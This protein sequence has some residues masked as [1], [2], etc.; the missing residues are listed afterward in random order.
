M[1]ETIKSTK[2]PKKV[3]HYEIKSELGRGGMATVYL[4]Y[5]ERFER[6]VAV[7]VL[8]AEF[9]HDP[10]FSVRFHREAKIIAT[11][12]HPAIVPVYDVGEADGLP[13]FVMRY[14][15]GGSL[16]DTLAKGELNLKE[17]ARII[18]AIAPALDEA[19]RRGIIH[20]DLKPANILFD[21]SN[22]PYLSDFGIA[23]MSDSQT[24]VTGSAIIGTPA[25][26]SPEQARGLKVD[27]RSDVYA[28]GA[29]IYR[30][31]TGTRPFEGD[32]PMS[33]AVKH[34][35]DPTPDILQDNADLPAGASTFI[36]HAMAKEPDERFQT[37]AELAEALNALAHDG[38]MIEPK[39]L[40]GRTR[41]SRRGAKGAS[42]KKKRSWILPVVIAGIVVV[43]AVLG[44]MGF[45]SN[46]L[47]LADAPVQTPSPTVEVVSASTA[48]EVAPPPA[49]PTVEV[50]PTVEPSPTAEPT[51]SVPIF[52]GAD[53]IAFIGNNDVWMMNLDGS[54][55]IQLTTDG[56]EK[57]K[58]QW[59]PDGKTLI[60]L[61][62]KCIQTMDTE[63]DRVD[64]VTCFEYSEYFE[65]FRVSPSG[66]QLALSFNRE[67]FIMPFDLEALKDIRDYN[68]LV[69]AKRCSF[70]EVP[71]K[72]VRWSSSEEQLAIV[73]LGASGGVQVD[74]IRIMDITRCE[75]EEPVYDRLDEFPA[76]RFTMSGYNRTSPIIPTMDWD[77]RDLFL[78]ATNKRNDGF[79]Y[80][81][82]YNASSHKPEQ[83]D[84]TGK[85]CCYRD[86]S[87]S[88]DGSHFLV[89][90]QDIALGAEA[91]I[92][93]YY[94][95]FGTLGTGAT[96]TPI[97][98]PEGYFRNRK[99]SPQFALR[100]AQ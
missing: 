13:Y 76:E 91:E 56:A 7:K 77:G 74:T 47:P 82:A 61:V 44:G 75:E 19:H 95:R 42:A 39:T 57:E 16:A 8:P 99:E 22:Q 90:F 65:G 35:T 96:Y 93:I 79:G 34:I 46:F 48:T 18:N 9:L 15:K 58:L 53:K 71:V 50:D 97:E 78:L 52:G 38:K 14:M 10:Q 84:P 2:Q 30:M 26:M 36:Y 87:W 62:G 89:A 83:L 86:A 20:R 25:Y 6:E 85:I 29:I 81:Y 17:A 54:E 12:E 92:E 70:R 5:D 55:L 69:D 32:T 67:L 23:K 64:V 43:A 24:N 4:G 100:P 63:A 41:I 66:E 94:L 33:M 88:P 68:D 80:F 27:G 37:A 31:L 60:Y 72:D 73:F 49:S 11:L 45:L 51:P 3:D 98:M 21:R 1:D 59:L 28:L 40:V